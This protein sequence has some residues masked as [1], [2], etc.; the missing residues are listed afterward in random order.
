MRSLPKNL[1]AGLKPALESRFGIQ[2]LLRRTSPSLAPPVS[3]GPVS[4]QE[5]HTYHCTRERAHSQ[6]PDCLEWNPAL[7]QGIVWARSLIY[8]PLFTYIKCRQQYLYP[9]GINI[10]HLGQ[11]PAGGALRVV[12][13]EGYGSCWPPSPLPSQPSGTCWARHSLLFSW[14]PEHRAE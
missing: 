9:T 14:R 12:I 4:L 13:V 3:V 7:R 10:K 5:A 1:S 8:G 2:S 11:C 6:Q